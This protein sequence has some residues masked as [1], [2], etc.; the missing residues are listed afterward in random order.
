MEKDRLVQQSA[1]LGNYLIQNLKET[2]RSEKAV[3]T[4][5]GKGLMIGVELDRPAERHDGCGIKTWFII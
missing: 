4:V 5:R 2:L 3:V 1:E